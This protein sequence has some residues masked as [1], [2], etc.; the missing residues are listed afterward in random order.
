VRSALSVDGPDGLGLDVGPGVEIVAVAVAVGSAVAV[1]VVTGAVAV[2]WGALVELAGV[3]FSVS[4]PLDEHAAAT[5]TSG[6]PTVRTSRTQAVD[7]RNFPPPAPFVQ[8]F[9]SLPRVATVADLDGHPHS[10][11][12][13]P[14]APDLP[15][16]EDFA[17]S[18]PEA[19][20][21]RSLTQAMIWV[22]S[23]ATAA[24]RHPCVTSRP[25]RSRWAIAG[26]G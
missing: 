17:Q 18:E 14:V 10:M 19:P 4:P 5:T 22:P 6:T 16:L 20:A 1:G 7:L 21:Q 11:H 8:Q 9:R 24:Q 13:G 23:M 15:G 3:A 26:L 25:R 2:G 12:P